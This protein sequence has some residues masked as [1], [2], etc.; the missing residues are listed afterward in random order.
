MQKTSSTTEAQFHPER[1][2]SPRSGI[3]REVRRQTFPA[4]FP[5][6]LCLVYAD[7]ADSSRFCAWESDRQ[8]AGCSLWDE[9]T[10]RMSALGEAV[11]RYAGNMIAGPLRR[12]SFRQL[13]AE[14]E[15]GLNP[16]NLALYSSQQYAAKGFPFVPFTSD[17]EVLWVRGARL[18]YDEEIYVPASLVYPTF[19][20]PI[21]PTAHE[22]RTNSV[23]YAGIAAGATR[24]DAQRAA[25]EELFERDAVM[26]NWLSNQPLPQ[27]SVPEPEKLAPLFGASPDLAVRFYSFP[28]EFGL[29]VVGALVED[30]S[31]SIIN[32][33]TACRPDP[34]AAMLKAFAEACQLQLVAQAL[35]DP[36]SP[37][38]PKNFQ[39]SALKA[40][41]ADRSYRQAYRSDWRD[42]NDLLCQVQLY[43]DPALRPVLEERLAEGETLTLEDFGQTQP[44]KLEA[45]L[46]LL[47][48]R[49]FEA[50]W[51]DLTT[52]DIA[53][54]GWHVGRVIV[55]GLYCNAPAA[56]PFLGGPRLGML[57]QDKDLCGLPLPYA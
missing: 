46:D 40:W 8:T 30:K 1:L 5:P 50:I 34:Q 55:P 37:L 28:S 29:P 25:I 35:D 22:P 12:A 3:V 54:L 47:H 43:L 26:L 39:Q 53:T 31:R 19:F 4:P 56:F 57:L 33:G 14:G 10:A 52:P 51:V 16:A 27:I 42:V 7:L 2:V 48:Q 24:E 36:N 49:R 13:L 11:E 15:N 18:P 20:S 21:S 6:D 44:R 32:M 41:R 23:M 17:L 38:L 9:R 45:Y